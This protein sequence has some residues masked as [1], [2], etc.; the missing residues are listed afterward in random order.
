MNSEQSYAGKGSSAT[1]NPETAQ[2]Q[3]K[4]TKPADNWANATSATVNF[5]GEN[6]IRLN[7][8]FGS[9]MKDPIALN[10]VR[11]DLRAWF[12]AYIPVWESSYTPSTLENSVHHFE[13]IDQFLCELIEA[14]INRHIGGQDNV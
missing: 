13:A 4:T 8:E 3:G 1:S 11:Q 9:L 12:M 6:T 10:Y 14:G 7:N 5:V 2:K